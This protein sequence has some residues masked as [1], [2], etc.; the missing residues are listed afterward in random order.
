LPDAIEVSPALLHLAPALTAAK[1]GTERDEPRNARAIR[2][3]RHFFLM[4]EIIL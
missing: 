1:A 2:I 3:A 4:S